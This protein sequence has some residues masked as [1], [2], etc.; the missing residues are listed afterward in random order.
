MPDVVLTMRNI[1]KRF[2]SV[3]ALE[4]V[5]L[6]LGRGEV[7][8]LVGENGAGKSTLMKILS[9]SYPSS[10]YEGE[11]EI[12]GK[13]VSFASTHDAEQAGIQMIYQE[14]SLNPDLSV[15][16]NVFLGNL[17]RRGLR[18]FVNWGEVM[19][20]TV[21]A[22]KRVGLEVS[23]REVVRR[24]S[25]SQQQLI[26]IAK[27]LYRHPHILVLDEPTS[28]LTETETQT[29][30]AILGKLRDEGI[31]CIYIS[32]KLDEVFGIAD[33]IT[34][35]RDGHVISTT[36]RVEVRPERIIEDMVGRKIET[37][38][39]K[40]KLPLGKEVLRVE[41][42]TVASR[43]PGR[44]IVQ[45]VSFSVRAGEILGLGGLVGSGRSE[46]INA[47]FGS[48][49]RLAG[50]VFIDGEKANISSPED[51]IRHRMGLLTEDRRATGYVG[52][53]NIRENT[54]L[55]SFPKIFGK[56]FI[57]RAAEKKY[58]EAYFQQLNVRAPGIE[59]SILSLSGGNQQK[60]VLAKWLLTDVR[61]LFLDEPTR[62]IDVG[63][64]V[65]IYS[66]MTELA[67]NGV[68]IVM[69]SSE[70]PELLAMCDRFVVLAKGKSSGNFTC[71]EISDSLFMKA[72]TGMYCKD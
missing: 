21:E 24:L 52:T 50:D 29:L 17:P 18:P 58:A 34:V 22:L 69:I 5:S 8:A 56:V 9:G 41:G 20:L 67:R 3:T 35:L 19:S 65:E 25:T 47:V 15:G 70:L 55:A 38:Y 64:K 63:A 1:T 26:S 28:A 2:Y 66:I 27:A 39:P 45:D 7:H 37:M 10:A 33:R 72:A 53:M 68:A 44:P 49:G 12:N 31:S 13:K 11:I 54:T 6:D 36:P 60:V 42:F 71:E 48:S 4:Q 51:S 57:H 46:L 43:I 61:V 40:V 30:M 16:E 23:P 32:H 14:I 59:T 62:G